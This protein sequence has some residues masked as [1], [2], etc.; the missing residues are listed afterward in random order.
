M[1]T[2]A[3]FQWK[4][5]I[6]QRMQAG[7][8]YVP[9]E[10]RNT[11]DWIKINTNEFPFDPSPDVKEAIQKAC[12]KL[13]YYPDPTG[14]E[15]REQIA[16]QYGVDPRQVILFNGCDDALN[17]CIRGLLD[18]GERAAFLNPSYSLY[19]TLLSNQAVM[20]VPLEYGPEFALP[21]QSLIQC[22]AK[23][24][25]LTSPNAPSGVA[26]KQEE[27]LK[28][29]HEKECIVV[30]D[31]TYGDFAPWS[32]IPLIREFPNVIVVKSFSK[33]FGLA[34]LR[35]GFGIVHPDVVETFH[36]IRDVYNVDR[37]AQAAGVAALKDKDYYREKHAII[38]E[39]RRSFSDF[40]QGQLGWSV[41]PS[42]TNF[43]FTIP[44]DPQQCSSPEI[45]QSLYAF[46]VENRILVRYFSNHPLI[47]SG[48]RIS[49]GT[50]EQMDRVQ[51]QLQQWTKR[52]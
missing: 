24:L 52:A 26:F 6:P 17:C 19:T 5:Y 1:C 42:A 13:R 8:A 41:L 23:M 30:L 3:T 31:E 33:T 37:L 47:A 14:S 48:L 11:S 40:L 4:D 38:A 2:S 35:L 25:L 10:Q 15:L 32:A 44:V 16:S 22:D 9:G 27:L 7:K 49:I 20:G 45:A 39:T 50:P 28:L 34:G 29:L 46:L 18:P 36:K 21:L 51:D 12:G 43:V